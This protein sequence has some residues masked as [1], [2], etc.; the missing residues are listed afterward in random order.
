MYISLKHGT[1]FTTIIIMMV[2]FMCQ[3]DWTMRCP[4]MV[5]TILGGSVRVFPDEVN[6]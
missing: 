6:I 5:N 4:D 1:T 3:L 2:N